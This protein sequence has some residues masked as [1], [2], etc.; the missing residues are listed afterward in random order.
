MFVQKPD[1]PKRIT[2]R[3]FSSNAGMSYR[4]P[5]VLT[6]SPSLRSVC[7]KNHQYLPFG[8]NPVSD[9]YLCGLTHTK[10][11]VGIHVVCTQIAGMQAAEMAAL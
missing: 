3:M 11:N 10:K 6:V 7:K 1:K 2:I 4:M 9:H 5:S 8:W